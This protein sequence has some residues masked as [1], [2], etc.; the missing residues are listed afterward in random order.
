MPVLLTLL[1]MVAQAPL[2]EALEAATKAA[3]AR[4]APS[5]VQIQSVGGAE[6]LGQGDRAL[7]RGR[8]P[9]TGLVVSA[10]GYII[11]SSF[12]FV[13]KPAAITVHLPGGAEPLPAKIIA[14]DHTRM[15]TLLKIEQTGLP[16]PIAAPKEGVKLGQWCVALGRTWSEGPSAP[17]SVSVGIVS[18]VDRIWG[19]AIQTDCKVSPV[20][21]GGPLIDLEGRVLGVLVPLSPRG[22]DEMAGVDWYDGGIGFA[23]PFAD[24][25]KVLPKLKA[26]TDLQKGLLGVSLK[27]GFAANAPA[28]IEQVQEDSPARKAELQPGD[29]IVA[30]DG[31]PVRRQAQLMHA[32]G[33]KYAGERVALTTRRDGKDRTIND[34][35]LMAPPAGHSPAWLGLLPVR[36]EATND[37]AVRH[38]FPDS[39]AAKAGVQPGDRLVALQD[40]PLAGRDDLLARLA[41]LRPGQSIKVNVKRKSNGKAETLTLQ[42]TTFNP[43][44]AEGELP[45]ASAKQA[46]KPRP[47]L[48]RVP[49]MPGMP[50]GPR[51]SATA[52]KQAKPEG[53]AP[54]KGFFEIKDAALGRSSWVYVP[55]NYDP[56]IS[57]GLLIWLHPAGE[58]LEAKLREL[59]KPWCDR[60][61]LILLAP[62]ADNP[63]GW[64]TSELDA[65]QN[66]ARDLLKSYTIDRERIAAHGL[67]NGA[68][69]AMLLGFDARALVR[70]VA[71]IGGLLVQ[72]A[73]DNLA[74]QR[75]SFHLLAGERDPDL[76]ELKLVPAQL[77]AKKY[78]VLFRVLPGMGTGYPDADAAAEI[79]RWLDQLDRF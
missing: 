45:P 10:D 19:K 61:H 5:V 31:T 73:K 63:T 22:D 12:N 27:D 74:G 20:N 36:D 60:H 49:G 71:A 54:A 13:N 1:C 57:H 28:L 53:P 68:S 70:G 7:L 78:P 34:F 42:A 47:A 67:G 26:G 59:W 17:P 43:V 75:L 14:Q 66:D 2:D 62:R 76:E 6:V 11:S 24:V 35:E 79:A 55:E 52:P 32:I 4:V 33:P 51:P 29:E 21:Y 40:R 37:V 15:L 3:A 30:V 41:A 65:I 48:P 23:I 50:M 9:T 69:F 46:L 64:L 58:T 8:G 39:P 25:L 18:A 44:L 77:R 16:V 56:N 38:V 72:P